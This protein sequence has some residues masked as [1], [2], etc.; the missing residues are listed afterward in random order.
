L[1]QT[2][3]GSGRRP[4]AKIH[5]TKNVSSRGWVTGWA[6]SSLAWLVTQLDKLKA[7]NERNGTYKEI[8]K[9]K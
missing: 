3:D 4:I 9:H 1:D 6:S 2:A 7:S 5:I 8:Q